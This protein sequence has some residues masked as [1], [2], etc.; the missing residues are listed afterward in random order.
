MNG[1]D[2]CQ[3]INGLEKKTRKN[4]HDK[5]CWK[6]AS[7]ERGQLMNGLKDLN[8]FERS[9]L[10]NGIKTTQLMNGLERIQLPW[11]KSTGKWPWKKSMVLEYFTCEWSWKNLMV[12]KDVNW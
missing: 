3:M 4:L 6:N 12:F 2:R 10:V 9:K 5:W 11:S 1:L 8:G 7:L